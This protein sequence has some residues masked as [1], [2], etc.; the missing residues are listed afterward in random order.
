MSI[1]NKKLIR[2]RECGIVDLCAVIEVMNDDKTCINRST[3]FV[4]PSVAKDLTVYY[5]A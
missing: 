2:D 1:D 5:A 4:I 3:R